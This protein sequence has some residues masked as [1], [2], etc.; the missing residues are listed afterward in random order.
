METNLA[1]LNDREYYE[2]LIKLTGK[3]DTRFLVRGKLDWEQ[4][5]KELQDPKSYSSRVYSQISHMINTRKKYPSFSRG[6]LQMVEILDNEGNTTKEVMG[7]YRAYSCN[8]I[9]VLLN[10]SEE[11]KHIILP[12]HKLKATRRIFWDS[13]QVLT[14]R[15][16]Q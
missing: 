11:E 3:D 8:R 2:E 5:E 10:L 4:I 6:S 9:L 14:E 15:T 16:N 7:Y 13:R 1:K 12:S